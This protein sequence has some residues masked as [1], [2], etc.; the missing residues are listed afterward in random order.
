M[1]R[2]KMER[3]VESEMI[4]QA[5]K[6]FNIYAH[7]HNLFKEDREYLGNSLADS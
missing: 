1:M 4:S 2:K 5:I 6:K 3:R 7:S